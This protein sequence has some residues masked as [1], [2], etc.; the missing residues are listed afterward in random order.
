MTRTP[1]R[2]LLVCAVAVVLAGCGQDAPTAATTPTTPSP[3]S[4]EPSADPAGLVL[5][6][7]D[8]GGFT[9]AG[10]GLSRLPAVSVY[11]DGRVV[12][13]ADPVATSSSGAPP[14]LPALVVHDVGA[15]GVDRLVRLAREAG[16]GTDPDLGDPRIA[17]ATTTRFTVR[18][19]GAAATTDAYALREIAGS[20]EEEA[21][22]PGPD[23]GFAPGDGFASDLTEAQ[24]GERQRLVD[25]R[26]A[27]VDV[28]T[29][30]GDA[31]GPTGP[32]RPS[33]LV[34][35]AA[36]L[37]PGTAGDQQPVPWPGPALPGAPTG[38]SDVT[39]VV[40]Q[41]AA[42]GRALAAAG[43]ADVTGLW[44]SGGSSW[45]LTFR[46]LLPDERGC[47]DLGG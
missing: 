32:Y 12:A 3:T 27:L 5:R 40:A 7:E 8:V 25:L 33:A 23:A 13:P 24:Q 29:T 42:L 26:N 47:A 22:T 10:A 44:S 17:D 21:G 39:C 15:D 31:A 1:Y 6:V 35:L 30:L 19:D 36:P 38:A 28:E 43:D 46:P 16:V 37:I 18:A 14:A 4:F 34:V 45:V 9:T 2:A 20:T 11:A 41:G